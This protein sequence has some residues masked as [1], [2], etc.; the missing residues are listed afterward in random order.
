MLVIC[1]EAWHPSSPCQ[2]RNSASPGPASSSFW[3]WLSV[4]LEVQ[5]LAA[6]EDYQSPS[7]MSTLAPR[8]EE[9]TS[10]AFL[11]ALWP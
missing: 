4:S 8:G 9:G 2:D 10:A 3:E 1:G 6:G 7:A 11:L 5:A